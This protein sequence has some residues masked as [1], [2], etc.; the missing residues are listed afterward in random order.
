MSLGLQT[1]PLS[2]ERDNGSSSPPQPEPEVVRSKK[3]RQLAATTVLGD[4]LLSLCG[5]VV[6]D[7]YQETLKALRCW[8]LPANIRQEFWVE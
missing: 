4:S 6:G 8:K 7:T 2:D 5:A 3:M 1:L